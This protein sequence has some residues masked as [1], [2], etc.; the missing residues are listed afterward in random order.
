MS[1]RPLAISI[2]CGAGALACAYAA[3]LLLGTRMWAVPPT[4]AERATGLMAIAVAA[5]AL[6]GLWRMQRWG[7]VLLAAA[8]AA[9]VAYGLATRQPWSAAALAGPALVLVVALVYVRKMT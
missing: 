4:F 3:V 9:R 1:Q 8:L 2:V 7:V 6:Y 5:A